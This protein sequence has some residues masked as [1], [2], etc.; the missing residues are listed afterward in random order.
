[1]AELGDRLTKIR[2]ERK[3]TRQ[4][5]VDILGVPYTTV[6]SWEY[7]YC[8]PPMDAMMKLAE[9]Y[10]VSVDELLGIEK[11]PPPGDDESLVKYEELQEFLVRFGILEEGE[12]LTKSDAKFVAAI[13]DILVEWSNLRKA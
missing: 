10:G 2:K 7:G 9:I 1:M 8:E 13:V 4:K 12:Q 11:D 3:F 6:S 5:V